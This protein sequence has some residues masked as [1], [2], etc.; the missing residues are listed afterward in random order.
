MSAE[1]NCTQAFNI[2]V[3]KL[4]FGNKRNIT[5][6]TTLERK[7]TRKCN[8]V[9]WYS[10]ICFVLT[11]VERG[12]FNQMH[13]NMVCLNFQTYYSLNYFWIIGDCQLVNVT[14]R[15]FKLVC[16]IKSP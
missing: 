12:T 1:M 7:F 9:S 13:I 8:Q 10:E 16:P 2:M 15:R 11:N 14:L 4:S 5:F 6:A 3:N